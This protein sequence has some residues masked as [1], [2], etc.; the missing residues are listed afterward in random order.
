[1]ASESAKHSVSPHTFVKHALCK[2]HSATSG[3]FG[4]VRV[5]GG[6]LSLRFGHVHVSGGGPE[7]VVV[8]GWLVS[9][10]L[11]VCVAGPRDCSR[12]TRS[13]NPA[14]AHD[15]Y[16]TLLVALVICETRG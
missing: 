16:C 10:C 6:V 11:C 7:Y 13:T 2:H 9:V 3:R 12:I 4:Y 5:S 15:N 8:C 1:M 14:A